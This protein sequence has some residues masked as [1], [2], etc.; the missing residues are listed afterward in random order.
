[1]SNV[2]LDLGLDAADTIQGGDRLRK[3]VDP[4]EAKLLLPGWEV[5]HVRDVATSFSGGTPPKSEST[6]WIGPVPWL[7][8]KDMKTTHLIDTEDHISAEAAA[9][10]SR[11]MPAGSVFV[12][13]RGM[14]LARDLPVAITSRP[15][16]FNQDMKALVPRE[17]VTPE[18]LLY[19]IIGQKS[20]MTKKIGTSAHGTR[21]ISSSSIEEL[22]I[23]LPPVEEQH[24]IASTLRSLERA[25]DLETARLRALQNLRAAS[26]A[27]VFSAGIVGSRTR[28]SIVGTIPAN[29]EVAELKTLL[30]ERLRNG[31]SAP[32]VSSGGGI[33]TLT[34]TAV[35]KGDFSLYNT[36]VTSADPKR[37]ADLW[38]RDGDVFIERAN[39]FEMVGLAALFRGS[40]DFAIF[41]DLL[42]RVRVDERRVIPDVLAAWLSTPFVRTFFQR[43]CSGAATSMPK[44]DQGTIE[45][46]PI[47]IPP[48]AEQNAIRD[49][50][51]QLDARISISSR[52]LRTLNDLFSSSLQAMM[53]GE[54]G[55]APLLA[56]ATT[57][58]A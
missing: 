37:V 55:V 7:S 56:D 48:M 49:I 47:P 54:L 43:H 57:S 58:H 41:P 8:P 17:R 35:T 34:L 42:V 23:P 16:A 4:A 27:R 36:K 29:W 1:M 10:Y 2:P 15:M 45:R 6:H 52:R 14:I 24:L 21:R 40:P 18:Y 46:T 51:S 25:K 9:E 26:I 39:T 3:P 33:R 50:V 13:I 20:A 32:A 30:R 38:L 12:V 22:L 28:D 5:V 19:A 53:S 44:I 31:H 11:V